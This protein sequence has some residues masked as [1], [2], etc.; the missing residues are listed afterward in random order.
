MQPRHWKA[1]VRACGRPL[2]FDKAAMP[3][4][5]LLALELQ[6]HAE[7]VGETVEQVCIYIYIYMCVCVCV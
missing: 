1:L 7:A 3:L 6:L 5:S 2:A 4:G